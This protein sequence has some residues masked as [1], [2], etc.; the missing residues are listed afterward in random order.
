MKFPH[1]C[2]VEMVPDPW[3]PVILRAMTMTQ[4][5]WNPR[6]IAPFVVIIPLTTGTPPP[7]FPTL[8]ESAS[9]APPSVSIAL[10]SVVKFALK[11]LTS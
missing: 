3:T 11:S 4:L 8:A 6:F 2:H 9:I 10:P 1:G 7:P 5:G